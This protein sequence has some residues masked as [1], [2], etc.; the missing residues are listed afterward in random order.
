MGEQ[1]SGPILLEDNDESARQRPPEPPSIP[2]SLPILPLKGTVVF[3]H[4]PLPLVIGRPGSMRLI[5]QAMV[6]NRMVGLVLQ[7]D[8]AAEDPGPD[9]LHPIGTV[10]AIQRLLK[11]PD[12]TI[13]I[14]VNGLERIR[15]LRF[16]QREPYLAADI[17][18]L[19]EETEDTVE[20]EALTKNLQGQIQ[21]VL[22]LMPIASEELGVAL[23]NVEEPGRLADLGAT[24]LVREPAERQKFLETLSVKARLRDLTK[25][26][27]REIEVLEL[28][29]KIQKEVQDELGKGQREFV[30]RQQLKAIQKELGASDDTEAE[31]QRLQKAIVEAG[32]PPAAREAADR[33]MGRLRTMSPASAEYVVARTYLDW[34]LILPWAKETT[35]KI[36]LAEARTIL[37]QDHYDLEK[38]KD[39]ILEFL[40]VRKLKADS[41]GP[42]LCF[43]G[44]PG[45]GKTSLGRSIARAM[46]RNFHRLSLGGVRDEAEIRGHRRTYVGALPGQI[47]QALRKAGSRNPVLMLDEVDKLGADF[48][49]DPASALL[50]VLDPEQNFSYSDHYLDVPFDLSKVMFIT[51]ANILDTIP[52]PLLDRMEVIELPGYIDEEKLAIA[53]RYLVPRQ[54]K[55][56]GL[57]PDDLALPDKSLLAIIQRY[58]MEA[59]LRN[60]EREIG[61]ICRKIA[62]RRAEGDTGAVTV[63]PDDLEGFLGPERFLHERSERVEVPGV[64]V[65]IA[66][67]PFGGHILFIEATRMPGSRTLTITGQVGD[68][69]RESAIAALSYIRSRAAE[70]GIRDEVFRNSDLHVH[71]PAGA[72]PK[73]GPSAGVTI[74]TAIAS[75]LTGRRFRADT[76]MTG[77]ITLRGKVLPIG[78]LKQKVLGAYRAGIRRVIL[79][80]EN[81][82]DLKEVPEQVARKIDFVFVR[83]VDD[84]LKQA[85]EPVVAGRP[86]AT[87]NTGKAP[88]RRRV[89]RTRRPRRAAPAAARA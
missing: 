70:L 12:G 37:D 22:G 72:V 42:I 25:V 59:G 30:L 32:M 4:I 81:R 61:S 2:S 78:G 9:L 45:T 53:R 15:T 8:P 68:V 88:A 27:S 23:L 77:E 71:I 6:G 52:R 26:V 84:V 16:V 74:A 57:A 28:G 58:T 18:V 47:I 83:T 87:A 56:N 11:F 31:I 21:K 67:T 29:T 39:R 54:C 89:P 73:D 63:Q 3:P 86:A 66:W 20:I 43:Y 85:L 5:D 7:R 69:M 10:A 41:K 34:L 79:P 49:G 64:A 76:A 38:V 19:K 75:L 36:D 50:E 17:E 40:A 35:D 13:R 24:L 82:K 48:R 62:R 46:G 80:V 65:G 60:L 55:E 33:E 1:E 51:T 44:P 14:L